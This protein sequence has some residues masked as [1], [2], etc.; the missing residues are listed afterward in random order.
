MTLLGVLVVLLHSR[1]RNLDFLE[2]NRIEYEVL[3]RGLVLR[4]FVV[5]PAKSFTSVTS[6]C[7][8]LR[9]QPKVCSAELLNFAVRHVAMCVFV[10]LK[11]R[12]DK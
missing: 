4:H 5:W 9:A 6:K 11:H 7:F 10:L 1:R 8:C 3:A 12:F 2:E